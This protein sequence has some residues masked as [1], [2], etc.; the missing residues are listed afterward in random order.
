VK[1][2]HFPSSVEKQNNLHSIGNIETISGIKKTTGN[3]YVDT[4]TFMKLKKMAGEKHEICKQAMK[5]GSLK[6]LKNGQQKSISCSESNKSSSSFDELN[7]EEGPYL[8]VIFWKP[9]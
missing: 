3:V 6:I 1:T 7:K 9:I 8:A 2:E 5:S 4:Q